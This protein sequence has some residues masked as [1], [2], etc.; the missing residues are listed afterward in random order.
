MGV[1]LRS[2]APLPARGDCAGC[3]FAQPV[4]LDGSGDE[5][6]VLECRR[7]PPAV[8]IFEGAPTILFPQVSGGEWCGEWAPAAA[9]PPAAEDSP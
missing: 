5:E 9:F 8:S 7:F 3:A 2:R 6:L 1:E 4:I